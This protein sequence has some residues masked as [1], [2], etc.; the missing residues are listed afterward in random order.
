M[1]EI[2]RTM[3]ESAFIELLNTAEQFVK[4]W[5]RGEIPAVGL[6]DRLVNLGFHSIEFCD[7]GRVRAKY[8]N[9]VIPLGRW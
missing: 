6:E 4:Y 3:G 7:Y 2:A 1:A 9:A 5:N 8:L